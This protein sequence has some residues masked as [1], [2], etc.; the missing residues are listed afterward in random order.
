ML[1]QTVE[2]SMILINAVKLPSNK[3]AIIL[4]NYAWEMSISTYPWH[5]LNL[6]QSAN[7]T[8]KDTS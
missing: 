8:G 4:S 7:L 1:G 3:I 6:C 5:F 2:E